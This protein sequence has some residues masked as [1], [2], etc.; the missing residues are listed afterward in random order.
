MRNIHLIFSQYRSRD[1]FF[2]YYREPIHE[3]S[4]LLIFT[5]T[6]KIFEMS[7]KVC[8]G[9]F[10]ETFEKKIKSSA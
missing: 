9:C 6:V 5:F 10:T 1:T 2:A 8:I 7:L 3:T 4:H